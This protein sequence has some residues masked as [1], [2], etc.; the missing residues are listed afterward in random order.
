MSL[1]RKLCEAEAE[2]DWTAT[3]RC[4]YQK[5]KPS[6][7]TTSTNV[8]VESTPNRRSPNVMRPLEG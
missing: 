5:N 7:H 1:K 8:D 3:D 6:G 4:N 2:R